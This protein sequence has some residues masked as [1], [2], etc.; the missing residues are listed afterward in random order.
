VTD[1][2]PSVASLRKLQTL[3]LLT[4]TTA[5]P[6]LLT[7]LRRRPTPTLKVTLTITLINNNNTNNIRTTTIRLSKIVRTMDTLLTPITINNTLLRI[8]DRNVLLTS[9]IRLRLFLDTFLSPFVFSPLCFFACLSL[10]LVST[11]SSQRP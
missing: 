4:Q 2:L 11:K 3:N 10:S 6:T 5:T 9:L 7:T 1:F 8:A